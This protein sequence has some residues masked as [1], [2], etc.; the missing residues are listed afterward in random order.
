MKSAGYKYIKIV[1]ILAKMAGCCSKSGAKPLVSK[2]RRNRSD[3]PDMKV[4][5][6]LP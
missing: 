5:I 3:E 6:I 4:R 1:P 2:R